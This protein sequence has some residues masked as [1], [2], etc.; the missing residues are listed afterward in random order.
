MQVSVSPRFDSSGKYIGAF[1]TLIDLT[2]QREAEEALKKSNQSYQ[3][4][5]ENLPGLVYRVFCQDSDRLVFFNNL[6]ESL[7]GY[8]EDEFPGKNISSF[9]SMI[10]EKDQPLV[11]AEVRQAIAEKRPFEIRYRFLHKNKRFRHFIER[12]RPVFDSDGNLLS[13][14]GVIFD[15]THHQEV[16]E[17]MKKLEQC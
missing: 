2:E 9:E 6:V 10:D 3:A 4:L 12:G 8:S 14:D 13:I 16:E 1:G 15:I 7:T 5:A 11:V 17:S